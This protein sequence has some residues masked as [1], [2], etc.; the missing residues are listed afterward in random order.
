MNFILVYPPSVERTAEFPFGGLF[1][2][3]ALDR[4][5]YSCSIICDKTLPELLDELD[6][7]VDETTIAIGLSVVSTLVFKNAM[8]LSKKIK[9]KY[10]SISLIFG[11][12]AIIG[13]KEQILGFDPVDYVV[14]GDG[15]DA[16]P[17]LLDAL[18]KGGDYTHITGVGYKKEGRS[19]FNG[20]AMYEDFERIHDLPYDLLGVE[21]YTRSLIIGGD[22]WLG[23]IYSRGCPFKC[24]FCINSV[25]SKNIGKT[26]YHS[27]DHIFNDINTLIKKYNVDA[28]TIHDDNF[29]VN[30]NRIIEFCQRIIENGIKIDFRANGRID[31]LSQMN[32]ETFKLL[33]EAGFVNIISGIE[34]GSTRYLRVLDKKI[35]LNQIIVA[36][37]RLTDFGFYKH[38]NFMTAMPG[39]TME[40]VGHTAWLVSQ[41]AKSCMKS[42]YPI[43]YR[44]YIPLPGTKMYRQAIE[45]YGYKEP[46]DFEGWADISESYM[47]EREFDNAGQLDLSKRPWVNKELGNYIQRVEDSVEEI[48]QLYIGVE[49][50]RKAII[51]K[52]QILENIAL[53]TI[54]GKS[55]YPKVDI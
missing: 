52:I 2:A 43:S 8:I 36:D 10:P 30:Q 27:F 12:Q 17:D 48:N 20:E 3:E 4:R 34:T 41:L 6:K 32:D 45:N 13:Q 1:L 38:W 50:D 24:T 25:F 22:R 23:A 16:L 55:E 28:I 49:S 14:V 33:R 40:D 37:R 39:E 5:G 31:T 47:T 46:K 9:E 54:K 19:V 29:L 51:E 35:T 21:N 26:R 42:P 18:N 11:G 44:K 15:E 7:K 53:E